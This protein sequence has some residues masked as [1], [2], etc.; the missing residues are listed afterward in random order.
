[1]RDKNVTILIIIISIAVP[2][3]VAALITFQPSLASNTSVTFFPKF[4][5]ILNSLATICILSGIFFVKNKKIKLHRF[6]M[7]AA[8]FLSAIF[9]V[10][11][12][13]AKSLHPA[14]PYPADAPLRSVYFFILISHIILSALILPLILF[15]FYKAIDNKIAQHRKLAKWTFPLWLY[16]TISGVVVYLFMAPHYG[17]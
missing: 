6:S 1:M 4:H 16:V 2:S 12:V 11:Y 7:L 9:L 17:V 10:S 15:T 3:L 8:F 13:V 14:T 5:A